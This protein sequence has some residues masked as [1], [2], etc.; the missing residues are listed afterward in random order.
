MS[1]GYRIRWPRPVSIQRTDTARASDALRMD[2]DL[3]PILGEAEMQSLLAETL[4]ADGW[5]E[6]D[7]R[8]QAT[9]R[10]AIVRLEDGHIS[11]ELK[12]SRHVAGRGSTAADAERNLKA[13]RTAAEER[14]EAD[15]RRK[16]AGVEAALCEQL[17]P[18]VQRVYVE[19]LKR[20]AA[21]M[22]EVQS[23]DER[24][25]GDEVE[26]TIKVKV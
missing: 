18:A 20:K 3:L 23:V 12:G 11:I 14:L 25:D 2:V 24:R 19:A 5:E 4:A 9:V 10:G 17:E 21:K 6:V 7:G 16:M 22:G 1:R 13:N 15:L 26:L 8:P